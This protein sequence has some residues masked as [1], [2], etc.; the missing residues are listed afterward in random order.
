M[1]SNCIARK[2]LWVRIPLRAPFAE[3]DTSP[4]PFFRGVLRR[5]EALTPYPEA[6]SGADIWALVILGVT[7]VLLFGLVLA[8]WRS[9]RE[10]ALDEEEYYAVL[11]GEEPDEGEAL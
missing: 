4:R 9:L 11:A 1:H 10:D 5:A 7:F 6:V 8:P 3:A 2:G